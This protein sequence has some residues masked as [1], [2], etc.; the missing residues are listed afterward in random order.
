[1]AFLSLLVQVEGLFGSQ[2]IVPV[3]ARIDAAGDV[4]AWVRATEAPTIFWITGAPDD[5]LRGACVGG[6]GLAVLLAAGIAP[7]PVCFALWLLYLSFV[8]VGS[9]FLDFQWDTLL[10]EA[11]FCAIFVAPWRFLAFGLV[12]E[13]PPSR[14]AVWMLR[15]VMFKLMLESGLVKLASGDPTWRNLTALQYHYWTTCLPVW[16]GW[17]MNLLPA[18]VHRASVAVM[19]AIELGAPF[20]VFARR[21]ARRVGFALLIGLQVMITAT[22]NYGFFNLVTLLLTVTML[23]D[24]DLGW[25]RGGRG[26]NAAPEEL[27]VARSVVRDA[28]AW[29]A[30][31]VV[32]AGSLLHAQARFLGADT[33]PRPALQM[34]AAIEP[35]RSVNSYGLFAAMTTRRGEVTVEGSNDGETW[36]PYEFRYKPGDVLRRPDFVQPHMPRLDWQMWFAALTTY[37]RTPWL[38]HFLA[39]LLEGSPAVLGLLEHDPFEGNPPRLVRTTYWDYRFTDLATRRET[40]AWWTRRELGRYGPT[41]ERAE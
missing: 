17:W 15:V 8:T 6:V 32:I 12:R 2:G 11:G 18:V 22:G 38:E 7:G 40:G 31:G 3:A 19:F 27:P 36:L 34:L 9:P 33:I 37:E 25:L 24:R 39:R 35:F 20:L 4:S 26:A 13:R 5:V 16:T 10:L 29:A 23:D 41:L 1:M 21:R 14:P 28:P 30:A